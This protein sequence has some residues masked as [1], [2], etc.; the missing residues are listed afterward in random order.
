MTLSIKALLPEVEVPAETEEKP[1]K[2]KKRKAKEVEVEAEELR[3]WKDD[4]V[5]GVSI[6]EMIANSEN[7]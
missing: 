3:E 5:S 4:S 6:A 7:K 2:G 1:A